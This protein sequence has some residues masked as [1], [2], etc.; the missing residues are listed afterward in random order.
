MNTETL[1]KLY[2]EWSLFTG[3]RTQREIAMRDTLAA[4]VAEPHGCVFCDSG[5]LRNPQKGHTPECGFERANL[6]LNAF[7]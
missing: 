6:L 7:C 4:I 2:L 5:K 1:D 3:A